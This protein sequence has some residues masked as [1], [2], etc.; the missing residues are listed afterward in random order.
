MVAPKAQVIFDD[1]A[2]ANWLAL[3]FVSTDK[4]PL[5]IEQLSAIGHGL[6]KALPGRLELP[7]LRLTALRSN[8]LSYGS[9]ISTPSRP[10]ICLAIKI[11]LMGTE[12][13]KGETRLLIL[14]ACLW[15]CLWLHGVA[16]GFRPEGPAAAST[17]R[18]LTLG[19]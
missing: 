4:H 5:P 8:Q 18:R 12:A 9:L 3:A 14:W 15:R 10:S 11:S 2:A 1:P 7:T 19:G 13:L 6:A 16:G 17:V